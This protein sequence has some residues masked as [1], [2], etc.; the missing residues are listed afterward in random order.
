MSRRAI[1]SLAQRQGCTNIRTLEGITYVPSVI[2]GE[3]ESMVCLLRCCENLEEIEIA[4]HSL[5]DPFN[6][7][8]PV[9][10]RTF[11]STQPLHLPNLRMLSILSIYHSPL[12]CVLFNSELPSLTKLTITPYDDI[13]DSPVSQLIAAHGPTLRSLLLFTPKSWPTRLHPSP[14]N[15]LDISPNLRHLSLEHPIP[16]LLLSQPHHLQ[17]LSIPRPTESTWDLIVRLLSAMP[18]LCAVRARD[19]RWLRKGMNA[20]AQE[21]GVQG[22]MREWRRRLARR[23]VRMLDA[24]W[25]DIE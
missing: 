13:P 18:N 17:F 9:D 23:G 21:A 12:L 3:E 16:N 7:E 25:R 1:L 10:R 15:L 4:G 19:V 22:T 20:R 5:I 6:L 24:E 14:S 8:H 2:P 11:V